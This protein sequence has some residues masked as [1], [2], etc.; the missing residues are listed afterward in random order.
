MIR[1]IP[2]TPDHQA[3]IDRMMQAIATEFPQAISDPGYKSA[4]PEYY[5]VAMQGDELAGTVALKL[6]R[7]YGV[8]KRMMLNRQFRGGTQGISDLLLQTAIDRCLDHKLPMLYLGTM[9]QMKA[10]HRFYEKNGFERIT[11][12]ELPAGFQINPVD[13]VFYKKRLI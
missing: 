4:A 12:Q 6:E 8:L 5:W 9:E 11:V 2:Y 3:S 1:I 7:D 10:A 13:D